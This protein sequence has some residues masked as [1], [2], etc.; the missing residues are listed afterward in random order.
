VR[1]PRPHAK[2]EKALDAMDRLPPA[3]P[4]LNVPFAATSMVVIGVV[5]VLR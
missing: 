4:A 1:A 2:K 5:V 3:T